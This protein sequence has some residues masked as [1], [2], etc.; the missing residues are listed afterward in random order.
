M[1]LAIHAGEQPIPVTEPFDT[2]EYDAQTG[3]FIAS[4]TASLYG[5]ILVD[6]VTAPMMPNQDV[7]LGMP[8]NS[9]VFGL[10]WLFLL[11]GYF[12]AM[13]LDAYGCALGF[14]DRVCGSG[15]PVSDCRHVLVWLVHENAE[16][17]ND[18]AADGV[19]I[20]VD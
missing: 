18:S 2:V 12:A 13:G 3:F 14:T 11:S 6:P 17:G 20:D 10:A 19:R 4:A 15:R 1:W 8:L 7:V 5:G 9:V 16:S